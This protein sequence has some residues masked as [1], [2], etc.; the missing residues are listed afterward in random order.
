MSHAIIRGSNGRRHEV[1]FGDAPVRVE[2]Y[3]PRPMVK[4]IGA[5]HW[6]VG[7]DGCGRVECIED[8]QNAWAWLHAECGDRQAAPA[9]AQSREIGMLRRRIA[10]GKP[11]AAS[12]W[13]SNPFATISRYSVI[14]TT[15][16][17]SRC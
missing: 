2:V 15:R 5:A 10:S 6:S 12:K 17:A 11:R 4:V 8:R 9:Q 13:C 7:Q 1:D 3:G 16:K 14:F